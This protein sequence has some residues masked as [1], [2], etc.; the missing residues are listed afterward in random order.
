MMNHSR[1][2]RPL[3]VVL[4]ILVGFMTLFLLAQTSTG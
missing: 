3:G 1:A 4:L 2:R